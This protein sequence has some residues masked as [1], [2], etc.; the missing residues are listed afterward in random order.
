MST[1]R[2]WPVAA[3]IAVSALIG[4]EG[5]G[6]RAAPASPGESQPAHPTEGTTRSG[7]Q[8][9][10]SFDAPPPVGT[11]AHCPVMDDDFTVT[12][13][14]PRS[15]HAGRHYVF[16]CPACKPQF[17]ADPRRYLSKSASNG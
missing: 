10:S 4:C 9:P 13:S 2:F 7:V 17:D 14:T 8:A 3:M 11:R 6:E 16:C 12:E 15:E 1:S 5:T